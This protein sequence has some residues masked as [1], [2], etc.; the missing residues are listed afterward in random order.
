ML[1][2][3]GSQW[4]N[5][6]SRL[7]C[8]ILNFMRICFHD[9]F[10]FADFLLILFFFQVT[11]FFLI[12]LLDLLYIQILIIIMIHNCCCNNIVVIELLFKLVLNFLIS[13]INLLF[14]FLIICSILF[15]R[16]IYVNIIIFYRWNCDWERVRTRCVV[17]WSFSA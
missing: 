14:L 8:S 6:P 11:S 9:I 17:W 10:E 7:P 3:F 15:N 2:F 16:Q 5:W 1:R 12:R 4:K 13:L